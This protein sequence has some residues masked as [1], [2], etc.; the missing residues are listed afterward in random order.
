MN[1]LKFIRD[2]N[3]SKDNILDLRNRLD[4]EFGIALRTYE[5]DSQTVHRLSYSQIDSPRFHPIADECRGL[6]LDENLNV[7]SRSFDRFYNYEEYVK[8]DPEY[9]G[10]FLDKKSIYVEE[11]V[12]GSLIK[13]YHHPVLGWTCSTQNVPFAEQCSLDGTS[14][15]SF[16][17]DNDMNQNIIQGVSSFQDL[18]DSVF[19]V[20]KMDNMVDMTDYTFIFE[21]WTPNNRAVTQYNENR[22]VLLA[23]RHKEG[24]YFD[25]NKLDTIA[26]NIGASRPEITKFKD[27]SEIVKRTSELPDL[28]EGFVIIDV[29]SNLRIKIKNPAYVHAHHLRTN[30]LM[31]M[32]KAVQSYDEREEILSYFPEYKAWYDAVETVPDVFDTEV[33]RLFE[34]VK[35]VT[36][37]DDRKAFAKELN[38]RDEL[39]ILKGA[40]FRMLSG[41]GTLETWERAF[42][43]KQY[44]FMEQYI[45]IK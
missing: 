36:G 1:L 35:D 45:K 26:E 20:S 30:G 32:K 3:Y 37:T 9:L 12:D 17:V 8:S 4:K 42:P 13:I 43:S 15:A 44:E 34:S 23:V 31:T 24:H 14:N 10:K 27:F 5:K 25:F 2:N 18:I 28:L 22:F 38:S 41:Q 6:I 11:K 19:D 40:V 7:L 39:E 21:L 33:K 29:Q 16:I